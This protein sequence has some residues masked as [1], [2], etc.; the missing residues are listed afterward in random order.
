MLKV[1]VLLGILTSLLLLVGYAIGLYIGNPIGAIEAAL[2]MAFLFNFI[3][4][5][6]SDRLVL[7]MTGARIV[8]PRESPRIHRIVE[9][10][11]NRAGIPKPRVAIIDSTAP[12]AFATG[13]GPGKSVVAVTKGLLNLLDEEEIEAVI[14]HEVAHIKNRDVLIATIAATIAGAISYL[15]YIGRWSLYFGGFSER[16]RSGESAAAALL[17]AILAPIAALI[18]Q[19]AISRTREYLADEVGARITRKPLELASALKKITEARNV[20]LTMNVNPATSHLWII[21]P[22]RPGA[23]SELFSTH[24]P[25]EKRIERLKK[26][27]RELGYYIT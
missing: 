27:A 5:F 24:P 12:N 13:R 9:R 17:A 3:A 20:G 21:N 11:A 8:S 6:Y 18:I 16:R 23:L 10:V 15:A 14:G 2:M 26:I 1:A 19:A 7:A 22:L 4:Y 25:V